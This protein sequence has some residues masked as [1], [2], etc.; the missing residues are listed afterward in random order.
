MRRTQ[1]GTE[2]GKKWDVSLP[3]QCTFVSCTGGSS[4]NGVYYQWKSKL[5]CGW[6]C[7]DRIQSREALKRMNWKGDA[8]WVICG[9]PKSADRILFTCILARFTWECLR[10]VLG[11]I[12]LQEVTRFPGKLDASPRWGLRVKTI[13]SSI[14]ALV[15]LDCSK[16]MHVCRNGGWG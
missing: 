8:N 7:Q 11:G 15:A 12:E 3:R 4:T 10:Q 14:C 5:L 9:K 13:C 16:Y 1:N 6:P 2:I